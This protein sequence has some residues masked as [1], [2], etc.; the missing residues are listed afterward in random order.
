MVT[1]N[2]NTIYS[3]QDTEKLISELKTLIEEF[4][5]VRQKLT[6]TL[7]PKEFMNI[8]KKKEVI[9]ELLAKLNGYAGLW[10][11]EN[12]ADSQ[13]NTHESK[14]SEL[15][16]DASNTLL[17]F[18]LWF[19]TLD[20]KQAEKYIRESGPYQ[21]YLRQIRAFKQ[22]TLS[23]K[24][25]QAIN[26]KDL[27]GA[28]AFSKM[29]DI[30]TNKFLFDWHGK[31]LTLEEIN[32]YK[33]SPKRAHRKTCYDK[34]LGKYGQEQ[35]VL[36]EVYKNIVN[37]WKNEN[38]KIRKFTSPIAVRNLSN[39][40]PDTAI[41]ALLNVIKKN[42]TLFQEYFCIK[43]KLC[44][45]KNKDRYDLY[46][47]YSATEKTYTYETAK[48]ITLDTYKQFDERAYQLAKKIF[49]ENHVHSDIQQGK[50]SG[51]FCATI[52]NNITPFVLLNYIGKLNDVFTM[53]HEF[54]HGIHG[55]AAQHQTPFTFHSA[56][57]LAETASI[58]GELLLT[59]RFLK[60]ATPQEKIAALIRELD[61]QYASIIRQAYFILFEK[62]AHE[63]IA[64]SITIEELNK[65][66]LENL[67][68]QF[69]N[70]MTV[71][72]VFQ[73][74]WKY[75]PHIYHTPFYCYAYAFGNLLVL[76][77]YNMY[78][79]EGKTFV[80]KYMKILSYGG[81][82]APVTILKEVGIDITQETFWQQ[83]F[84][85]IKHELEE[86]K[87]LTQQIKPI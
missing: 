3:F 73:H 1:W 67:K 57:P 18:D 74:E 35:E 53:M 15:S 33:Q 52:S 30:V 56:L 81:S 7:L 8:L 25:E 72:E 85:A 47:P 28:Q 23:E 80:P 2:L 78:E 32:Q 38:I 63:K 68:E 6:P 45:L 64:Q 48:Q 21:Y 26:L 71:P 4:K 36:G 10:L 87:K 55:L 50:Q 82:E 37:D 5:N 20:D 41:E 11:A 66:Y 34:V 75:I 77:L 60:E 86:L 17:F 16:A 27:T 44:K 54:G 24:E 79:K 62:E 70:S 19:K 76:A 59:K 83:G 31:K 51:A 22:Y 43:A 69:G 39:D 42:K 40:I 14:I 65:L 49:D 12:T 84:D 9:A 58:F 29:Y 13:R 61:G 46:A